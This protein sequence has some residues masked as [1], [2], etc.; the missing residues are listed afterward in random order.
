MTAMEAGRRTVGSLVDRLLAMPYGIA[1]AVVLLSISVFGATMLLV[2]MIYLVMYSPIL[3]LITV[4]AVNY[5]YYSTIVMLFNL[6][7]LILAAMIIWS[8]WSQAQT[9]TTYVG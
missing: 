9:R 1:V 8:L 7:P 6:I 5:T 2:N 4:N 3:N